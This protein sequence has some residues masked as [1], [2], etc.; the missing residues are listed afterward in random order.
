M[1]DVHFQTLGYR[2]THFHMSS[3]PADSRLENGPGRRLLLW[4]IYDG[5]VLTTPN[6][7][8]EGLTFKRVHS[9]TEVQQERDHV[10]FVLP[11]VVG[12]V[13]S[14]RYSDT[15]NICRSDLSYS[16][17]RN[18]PFKRYIATSII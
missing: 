7:G 11:S 12:F 2:V 17:P 16:T 18:K 6:M 10:Y 3:L 15:T 13:C 4:E 14:E 9:P 5:I 8:P 1:Q